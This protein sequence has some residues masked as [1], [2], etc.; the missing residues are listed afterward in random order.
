LDIKGYSCI[1]H[2]FDFMIFDEEGA[3]SVNE[4]RHMSLSVIIGK[5]YAGETQCSIKIQLK[6]KAETL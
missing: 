6:R 5:R 1:Y 2:I 3:G 4:D